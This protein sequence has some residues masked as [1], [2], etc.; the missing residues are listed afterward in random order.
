M[1]FI[2][3]IAAS[4]LATTA[5]AQEAAAPATAPAA[6][7]PAA[8]KHECK[9]PSHPGRSASQIRMDAFNKQH[10]AYGECMKKFIDEQVAVSNAAASVGNAAIK[11]YNDYVK[12]L[13][14]INGQ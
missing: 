12:A 4:L 11:E 13:N 1:K 3:L 7:A 6:A 14:E 5:F 9:A 2:A 10:K 8:P